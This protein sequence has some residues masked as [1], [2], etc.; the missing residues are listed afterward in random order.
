MLWPAFEFV[1]KPYPVRSIDRTLHWKLPLKSPIPLETKYFF[2][3]GK[4][5]LKQSYTGEETYSIPDKTDEMVHLA[6]LLI[7]KFLDR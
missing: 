1:E 6:Q 7:K 4:S 2:Q 5:S 3:S